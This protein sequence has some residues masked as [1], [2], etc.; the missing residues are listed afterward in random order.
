MENSITHKHL[1][2]ILTEID[3]QREIMEEFLP[4]SNL[5]GIKVFTEHQVLCMM[6]LYRYKLSNIKSEQLDLPSVEQFPEATC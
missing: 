1:K 5:D 2:S 4:V 3:R 6:D